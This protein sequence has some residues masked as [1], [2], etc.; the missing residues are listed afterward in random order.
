MK[1]WCQVGVPVLYYYLSYDEREVDS[2]T[3]SLVFFFLYIPVPKSFFISFFLALTTSSLMP[4]L[5]FL[6]P[7]NPGS[8]QHTLNN[9]SL[10]LS[11]SFPQLANNFAGFTRIDFYQVYQELICFPMLK[12]TLN[13]I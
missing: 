2:P 11:S 10:Q 8:S 3:I 5:E 4:N 6:S 7:D 12:R 1:Y 13:L 9:S